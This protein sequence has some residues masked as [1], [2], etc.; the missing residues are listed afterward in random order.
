M[1][2]GSV[3]H[4]PKRHLK[5]HVRLFLLWSAL[6][7]LTVLV[8]G[9]IAIRQLT[10]Q[11]T[12]QKTS[13]F[14][15]QVY[16]VSENI[17]NYR[18][19]V[20]DIADSIYTNKTFRR[21][22]SLGTGRSTSE[23]LTT[24]NEL[25]RPFIASRR[26][27]YS[28]LH[29]IQIYA[30]ND[31]LLFTGDEL[32]RVDDMVKST[33]WYQNA[34]AGHGRK[35]WDDGISMEGTGDRSVATIALCRGLL[36]QD[37]TLLG[38]LRISIRQ[39]KLAELIVSVEDDQQQLIINEHGRILAAT[40]PDMVD[41]NIT[42][43]PYL[44]QTE[45]APSGTY[46][47]RRGSEDVFV[48]H[49]T[50]ALSAAATTH[51]W[52]VVSIVSSRKLTAGV[53]T[54]IF[55]GSI[56]AF[57]VLCVMAVVSFYVARNSTLRIRE[58][59][60]RTHR[61]AAGDFADDVEV[62]GSDEIAEL[63]R[64][65]NEMARK[66]GQLVDEVYAS[67]I[68]AQ[69]YRLKQQETELIALQMQIHPHFLYNTLDAIRMHAV[70]E[71]NEAI[72]DMLL[73]LSAMLRYSIGGGEDT[74]LGAEIAHA[75]RYVHIRNMK[76]DHQ[77]CFVT[78]VPEEFTGQKLP[79]LLLQPIVENAFVHGLRRAGKGQKVTV[80][81]SRQSEGTLCIEIADNGVGMPVDQVAY[82]NERLQAPMDDVETLDGGIGLLNVNARLRLRYGPEFGLMMRST[83]GTGTI[84]QIRLP[85]MSLTEMSSDVESEE[86]VSDG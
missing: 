39:P 3:L 85:L 1:K 38:V 22:L 41:Q 48:M 62:H 35:I 58:L 63:G 21:F 70:I 83:P 13:E 57:A 30:D 25:I 68:Q 43:F 61:V 24:F 49:S 80:T 14:R 74:T 4:R 47:V 12:E 34:V 76:H 60:K 40:T 50:S 28:F 66:L 15:S 84:V 82:W 65:F 31:N 55:T 2:A 75:A 9:T 8:L 36:D 29:A 73:A 67:K 71:G 37:N 23:Q 53:R 11:A 32:V 45:S 78:Q 64:S 52:K 77:V 6:T 7:V 18:A 16:L 10:L 86:V 56:V 69:A 5:L 26:Y 42:A 27:S 54:L 46:H 44:A 19:I 17:R 72:A 81:V 59:V 20:E 79:R 33:T 51:N